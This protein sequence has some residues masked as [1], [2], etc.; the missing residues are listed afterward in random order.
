VNMEHEQHQQLEA[1]KMIRPVNPRQLQQ[2]FKSLSGST[3]ADRMFAF[4]E[5]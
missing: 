5:I 4:M 1:L 3:K 2:T